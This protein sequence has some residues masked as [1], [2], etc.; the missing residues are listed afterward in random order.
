MNHSSFEPV[1]LNC[2][3]SEQRAMVNACFAGDAPE[4]W[5]DI[6]AL[7][8]VALRAVSIFSSQSDEALALMSVNLVHQL[9][10][11]YGGT[12]PYIPQG[13]KFFQGNKYDLIASEFNGR[14]IREL[15]RK[16]HVSDT[17][18]R[19]II[20]EQEDLKKSSRTATTSSN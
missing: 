13:V 15:A 14:N 12:Q 19:Q 6:A 10:S 17:R 2:A 18:V 9:V 16:H 4:R 3:T 1:D 8:F 20:Q 5:R 7:N 11:S